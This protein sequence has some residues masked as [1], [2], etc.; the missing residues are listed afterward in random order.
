[1]VQWVAG[2]IELP[3]IADSGSHSSRA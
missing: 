2:P 3:V 1:L